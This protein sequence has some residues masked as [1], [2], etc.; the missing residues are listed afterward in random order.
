M[1]LLGVVFVVGGLLCWVV[2]VCCS[3]VMLVRG[4]DVHIHMWL[5]FCV[6]CLRVVVV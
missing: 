1:C 6:G 4:A 5:L 2:F 3:V